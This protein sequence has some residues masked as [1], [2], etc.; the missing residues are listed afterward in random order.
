MKNFHLE[1]IILSALF[2]LTLLTYLVRKLR[3]RKQIF[4]IIYKYPN[5]ENSIDL[6]PKRIFQFRMILWGLGGILLIISLFNPSFRSE[7]SQDSLDLKGVDIVF[8]VDVSLSMNADDNG[9]PRISRL[10]EVI[11]SLLPSLSSNRFG[12]ITFAG[13]P[14]LYCP[15]TSDIGA[16]SEYVRGLETDMIPDTGTN[17]GR[18]FNKLDA[19][20]D[21]DK[22]FKNKIVVLA[23]DGEDYSETIPSKLNSDLIVFGLG[24]TEGSLIRYKDENTGMS[25]Y[26]T[27]DGKLINS[28]DDSS[29]IKTSINEPFLKNIARKHNGEYVNITA[30]PQSADI[31]ISKINEMEKNKD[32]QIRDILKKDGYHFFLIPA[33]LILFFDFVILEWLIFKSRKF[34]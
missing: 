8:L 5:L 18:G 4:S 23:T 31:L 16:F 27:R 25:G 24:T 15:M 22:V 19:F 3:D 30:N 6:V 13:T 7:Q 26:I 21:S 1:Y 9:S 2:F 32:R 33:F 28:K 11:L 12:I 14:F 17:I 29:L 20:L 34:G 10:K